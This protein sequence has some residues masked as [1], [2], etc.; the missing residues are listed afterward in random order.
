MMPP[1][2]RTRKGGDEEEKVED[3]E[4]EDKQLEAT[5]EEPPASVVTATNGK[6]TDDDVSDLDNTKGGASALTEQ[7]FA[8]LMEKYKAEKEEKERLLKWQKLKMEKS[9]TV[10]SET[11]A[12]EYKRAQSFAQKQLFKSVKFVTNEVTELKE[13]HEKGS[14][15]W[16]VIR[17]LQISPLQADQ[18]WHTY[19]PVVSRGL[20]DARN[21]ASVAIKKALQGKQSWG[22]MGRVVD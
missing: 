8:S 15:G 10:K 12:D 2:R 6:T 1:K 5:D 3:V 7:S 4:N 19:K 9:T 21:V 13:C 17:G 11:D 18:Y 20:A 14:I 22:N 16:R